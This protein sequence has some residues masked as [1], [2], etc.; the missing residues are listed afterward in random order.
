[1]IALDLLRPV[2]TIVTHADCP[3]GMVS[4]ILLHDVLPDARIRFVRYGTSDR[5]DMVAEPN[6]LFCDMTPPE[7]RADQFLEAGA[8][9]LDHHVT[10]QHLVERF[11]LQ[12]RGI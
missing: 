7:A 3:D 8:I 1:M 5:E 12:G 6:M 9:V 4:A 10:A 11:A 2:Q